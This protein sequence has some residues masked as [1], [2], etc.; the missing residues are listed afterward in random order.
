[1]ANMEISGGN[2]LTPNEFWKGRRV[3]VTGATGIVGSWLVKELLQKDYD[4]TARTTE[5]YLSEMWPPFE[6]GNRRY[7][8]RYGSV[9]EM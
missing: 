1:M 4:S 3:F 8:R 7:D 9:P 2:R 6:G 5:D